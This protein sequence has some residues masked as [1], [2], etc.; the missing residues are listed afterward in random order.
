MGSQ[1]ANIGTTTSSGVILF[2]GRYPDL[3]L[4]VSF[5]GGKSWQFFV[6]DTSGFMANG[7]MLE[8]PGRPDEVLF[9]YG[10]DPQLP[11]KSHGLR[12]QL[13]KVSAEEGRVWPVPLDPAERR[14][15]QQL[16]TV[17]PRRAEPLVTVEV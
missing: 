17:A 16:V 14:R 15:W 7:A 2:A 3:G 5:S 8:L 11:L 12:M 10:G 4:Q 9:V 6:I 1:C 13:I